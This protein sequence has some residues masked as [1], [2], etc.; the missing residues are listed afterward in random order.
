MNFR[1]ADGQNI[2]DLK[3][4]MAPNAT[5]SGIVFDADGAPAAHV[6]VMAFEATYNSGRLLFQLTEGTKPPTIGEDIAC[7]IFRREIHDRRT[8]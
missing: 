5:I 6:R 4:P 7:S 8:A 1:I 3:L 2:N